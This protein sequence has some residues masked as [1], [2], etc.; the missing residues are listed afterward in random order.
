M[1]HREQFARLVPLGRTPWVSPARLRAYSVAPEP[2]PTAVDNRLAHLAELELSTQT[3]GRRA[4]TRA[5]PVVSERTPATARV[6]ADRA[7]RAA[8]TTR[9][10]AARVRLADPALSTLS[11][12]LYLSHPV[13][14]V[15]RGHFL[16][17]VSRIAQRVDQEHIPAQM[18]PPRAF[19]ATQERSPAPV[20]VFAHLAA[21][22][23]TP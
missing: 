12:A 11:T 6:P 10:T 15:A 5:F 8:T 3:K 7:I 14:L 17:V 21:Q 9:P 18:G 16:R 4:A 23:P 2:T 1:N 19:S 20:K 13:H 22:G